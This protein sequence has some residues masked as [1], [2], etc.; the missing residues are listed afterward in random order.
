MCG[1][2][3]LAGRPAYAAL[4][5]AGR[6]DTAVLAALADRGPDGSGVRGGGPVRAPWRLHHTRLSIVDLSAAGAQP[7]T[8]EDQR[9][10]M[11]FN[12]E[13][14]NAPELR[15]RCEAAGHR[16][17]STSDSEVIVHLWEDE[18]WQA[19]RRLDGIYAIAVADDASGEVVLARDPYGVKPLFWSSDDGDL[20]F[21]SELKALKAAGAPMGGPDTTAL[22]QFLTLLWVPDPLTPYAGARSLEPGAILRWTTQGIEHLHHSDVVADAIAAVPGVRPGRLAR[23]LLLGDVSPVPAATVD[24]ASTLLLA[25]VDRQLQADVPVRLLASGGVDSSL[26]WWAAA[27]RLSQGLTVEWDQVEGDE[28][29]HEDATAVRRMEAAFTTPVDY[30]RGDAEIVGDPTAPPESGDL[31]ADPAA[32]LLR[33]LARRTAA[34]GGKVLL[35]G[36]GGDEVFA[37]YR[38]HQLANALDLGGRRGD[39]VRPVA[40]HLA[41]YL[42]ARGGGTKR[43]YVSRVARAAAGRDPLHR[44]MNLCTYSTAVDRAEALGC[45]EAEV[46]DEVVW[47]RHRAVH[48]RLPGHWTPLRRALLLDL[49]VYMPGLGLAYAD[50]SGMAEGVEVRVPFLDPALVH[51]AFSLPDDVLLRL[52]E[53]KRVPKALARRVLP[54]GLAD[55]PKRGFGAPRRVVQGRQAS[56]PQG[57]DAVRSVGQR[58]FRQGEYVGLARRILERHLA[59][60]S[61]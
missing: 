24:D 53:A 28:G 21:A 20:W 2:A 18:G 52:T 58:G 14:Y 31:F 51:F 54:A 29:L 30:M 15:R 39:P 50:R 13:I 40:G 44:Y 8:G 57:P 1:I 7:M 43:E 38:R 55:R 6:L 19:L 23:E 59:G 5:D 16:F 9:L 36:Q 25:A 17:C 3:G 35:S 27:G 37:G 12:G 60:S 41:R 42:E 26:L 47:Q 10:W 61:P 33:A 46:A 48:D 4:A 22:A 49:T 34:T 56:F 11:V 45:T 32:G